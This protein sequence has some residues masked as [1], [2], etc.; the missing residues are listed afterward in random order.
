MSNGVTIQVFG[1]LTKDPE[2]R[3][4]SAGKPWATFSV[5]VN[6]VGRT[7]S[8]EK[9]ESTTYLDCKVFGDQAEHLCAS[10]G[11]G[12]RIFVEGKLRDEKWT[13]STGNERRSKTVY[14]DEIAVS[15]RWAT[16]QI[17]KAANSNGNGRE[18]A[19]TKASNGGDFTPAATVTEDENPFM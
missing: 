16:A 2:L 10:A 13:D 12:H 11:K 4:S 8:G 5:A 14:I 6:E 18:F 15:V 19:A 7:A 1:N 9:T 3:F 17:T